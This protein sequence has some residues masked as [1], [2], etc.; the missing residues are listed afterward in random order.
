MKETEFVVDN[1]HDQINEVKRFVE[2]SKEDNDH[3]KY[4]NVIS[5]LLEYVDETIEIRSEE[6]ENDYLTDARHA[7]GLPSTDIRRLQ[8]RF[9]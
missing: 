1:L 9:R 3:V 7:N 4:L 6:H 5:R 2:R 8:T